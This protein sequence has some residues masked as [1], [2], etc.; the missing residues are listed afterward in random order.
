[1]T[2]TET[3]TNVAEML[4]VF[5]LSYCPRKKM[6]L[7]PSSIRVALKLV[8]LNRMVAESTESP[9]GLALL[10]R[11]LTATFSMPFFG[12]QRNPTSSSH[13]DPRG[14]RQ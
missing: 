4:S 9:L 14:L 1:M 5:G 8:S 11:T 3:L 2:G 6:A 12:T 10:G 13:R 7:Y